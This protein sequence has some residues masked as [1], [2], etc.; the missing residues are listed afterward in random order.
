MVIIIWIQKLT[1]SRKGTNWLNDLKRLVSYQLITPEREWR[2]H[3]EC[4]KGSTFADLLGENDSLVH[5]DKLY[6]CLDWSIEYKRDFFT[7]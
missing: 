3:R 6:R 2:L 4:F 1:F 7:T 5:K